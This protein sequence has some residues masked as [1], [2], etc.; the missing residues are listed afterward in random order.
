MLLPT[1]RERAKTVGYRVWRRGNEFE[2][3]A[4]DGSASTVFETIEGVASYLDILEGK[5]PPAELLTLC[6]MPTGFALG[7]VVKDDN[8][9][10]LRDHADAIRTLTKRTVHDI[11]EIGRRLAEA[12]KMLGHGNF[13]PWVRQ[14]FEWSEDTAERLI[15]VHALQSQIPHVAELNLP[16]SGLYLLSRIS[17]PPEAIEAVV[18]KA[19][20]GKPVSVAEVKSVIKRS[21][22][23]TE[24]KPDDSGEGHIPHAAEFRPDDSEEGGCDGPEDFWQRSLRN[25]AGDAV[26]LRA[27]WRKHGYDWERFDAPADLITL[28]KQAAAEWAAIVAAIDK[29]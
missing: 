18:A 4:E 22:Q 12:K 27:L 15:A 20:S 29:P 9:A 19:Q 24:A 7:R 11:I 26:A 17:T 25:A 8:A 6:G 14:E 16:L 10:V 23:R 13:L 1:I 21:T 3:A 28:A 5:A 2:L